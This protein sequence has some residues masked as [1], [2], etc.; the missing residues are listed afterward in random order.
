MRTSWKKFKRKILRIFAVLER[1]AAWGLLI[2][3]IVTFIGVIVELI[4]VG[5]FKVATLL[6]SAD[7]MVS[8]F[9]AVQEAEDD[10]DPD[11]V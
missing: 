4:D 8:G 11:D 7:F 1:P 2:A 3:S 5:Q 10:E 6:L 9:S